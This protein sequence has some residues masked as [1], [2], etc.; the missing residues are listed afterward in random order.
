MNGWMEERATIGIGILTGHK[1]RM[2][3]VVSIP[4]NLSQSSHRAVDMGRALGNMA[5]GSPAV[6]SCSIGDHPVR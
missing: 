2:K 6:A 5:R 3:F 1:R 4:L